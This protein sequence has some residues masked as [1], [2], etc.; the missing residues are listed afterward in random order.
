MGTHG[1]LLFSL[2]SKRKK[3]ISSSLSK[4]R[5]TTEAKSNLAE[6]KLDVEQVKR[7]LDDVEAEMKKAVSDLEN[8]WAEK[9]NDITEISISPYK[10]DIFP[11]IYGIAW[12]PYY[13]VKA[14]G[15][16]YEVKAFNSESI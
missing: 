10:K 14:N 13:I 2:I 15:Q 1:E 9:V 7:D 5:M 3:S 4:R 12:I 16:T 8:K 6:Q 11:E